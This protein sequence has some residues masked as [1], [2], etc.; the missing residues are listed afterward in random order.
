MPCRTYAHCGGCLRRL[1]EL[2]P[3]TEDDSGDERMT[4]PRRAPD[5]IEKE[6]GFYDTVYDGEE[7]VRASSTTSQRLSEAFA[8][9]LRTPKSFRNQYPRHSMTLRSLLQGVI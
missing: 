8:K 2:Y 3:D 1:P 7:F 6:T 9:E 5:E 4:R